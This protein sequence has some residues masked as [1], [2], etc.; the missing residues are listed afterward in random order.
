MK[1]TRIIQLIVYN[2]IYKVLEDIEAALK[3]ML[4]PEFEE[5]VT[6]Q[7]EVRRLFKFSSDFNDIFPR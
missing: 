7:A 3:G 6:G 2:I 4:D 1:L 5:V